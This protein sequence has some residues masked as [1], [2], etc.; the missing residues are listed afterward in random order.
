M[1]TAPIAPLI[2][3]LALPTIATMLITSIYNMADT[4]FVGKLGT[5]ATAAVGVSFS[6]MCII[7]AIGFTFGMGSGNYVSRLLGQKEMDKAERV[8]TT[9]FLTTV[10]LGIILIILGLITVRPLVRLLGATET[11]APYAESYIRFILIG[12]PLVQHLRP[13]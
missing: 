5:S 12:A 3:S 9:G 10:A 1:T 6:L 11:I 4:Y 13:L 8:A 2:G 7:Q